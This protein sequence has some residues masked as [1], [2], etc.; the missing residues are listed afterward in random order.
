MVLL[1][2]CSV[3][4]TLCLGGAAVSLFFV[5]SGFVLDY[6]YNN[7]ML[8]GDILHSICFAKDRINKIYFYI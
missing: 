1:G 6:S 8:P 2:H 3:K 5:L 4:G 7:R